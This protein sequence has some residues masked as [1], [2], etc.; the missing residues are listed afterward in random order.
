MLLDEVEFL[1]RMFVNAI[2]A[3]SMPGQMHSKHSE[4]HI[5]VLFKP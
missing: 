2:S 5:L 4:N 1:S 3:H